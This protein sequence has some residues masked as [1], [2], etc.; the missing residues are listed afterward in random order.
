[1]KKNDGFVV[2]LGGKEHE[3][4]LNGVRYIVSSRFESPSFRTHTD[5]TFSDRVG[6]FVGSDFA[7]LKPEISDDKLAT[8]Y[9][10]SAAGKED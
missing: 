3:Y 6:S 2:G 10:C 4:M 8:E 1:M 7:D 5:Q 9:V